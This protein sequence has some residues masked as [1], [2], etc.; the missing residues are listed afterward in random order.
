ML[1]TSFELIDLIGLIC[2]VQ[3]GSLALISQLQAYEPMSL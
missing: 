2:L 3:H 1:T